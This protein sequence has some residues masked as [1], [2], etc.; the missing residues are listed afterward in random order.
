MA[1]K[2]VILGN[3]SLSTRIVYNFISRYYN[4]E[5]IILENSVSRK[6]FLK[7][8]IKK[9]GF[10][11]V[12][13]QVLFRCFIIPI[14]SRLSQKR[15]KQ[16]IIDNELNDNE[17]PEEIIQCVS[18][19]NEER[20]KS[21]LL[22]NVPDLVIVSGTRIISKQIIDSIPASFINIHAGITPKY[23]GV[24]GMYWALVNNDEDHAG[25]TVHFVDKGIDTGKIIKQRK[26]SYTPQDNFVTYPFLQ[27]SGGLDML[28]QV[29]YDFFNGSLKQSENELESK[30][31]H[32]PTIWQ[33]LYYRLVKGVK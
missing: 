31:W 28:K 18:S 24:H 27:L 4:V 19:V 8:R 30:L 32:H 25:V 26:I 20:A 23:R 1:I 17:M 29:V 13:G 2:L 7:K 14:L 3:N 16:I 15:I 10:C 22:S 6:Q 11:R 9:L 33:Y 21:I 12:L 5:Y